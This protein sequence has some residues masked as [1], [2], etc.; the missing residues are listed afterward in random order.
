M[1]IRQREML[2]TGIVVFLSGTV[3]ILGIMAIRWVFS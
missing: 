3:W 2:A 1:N